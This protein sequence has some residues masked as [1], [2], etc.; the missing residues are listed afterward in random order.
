[1]KPTKVEKVIIVEQ[2]SDH[3]I[4][5]LL[6][7]QMLALQLNLTNHLSHHWAV[8]VLALSAALS[9]MGSLF[10]GILLMYIKRGI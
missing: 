10:V 8:T 3:E 4:L 6:E 7:A 2:R 9:G 5:V 1:M